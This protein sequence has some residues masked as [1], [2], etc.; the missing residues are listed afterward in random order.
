[1]GFI[2]LVYGLNKIQNPAGFEQMLT[3]LSFPAP[4]IL[5]WFVIVLEVLGGALLIAGSLCDRSH[6]SSRSRWSFRR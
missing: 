3:G 5:S 1:V 2:F 6:S 4:A